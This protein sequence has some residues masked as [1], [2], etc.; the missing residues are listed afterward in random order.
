MNKNTKKERQKMLLNIIQE[1]TINH[2]VRLLEELQ[3]KGIETTQATISRDLQ[4]LGVVKVRT[5]RGELAYEVLEKMP[6]GFIWNN[7]LLKEK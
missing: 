3:K 5:A 2:Q 6:S 4:E 7:A 1:Q